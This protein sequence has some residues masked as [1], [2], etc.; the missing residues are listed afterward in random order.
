[1][2]ILVAKSAGFCYGVKRAIKIAEETLKTDG[3]CYT[4][5]PIIHNP[6]VVEELRKK[7]LNVIEDVKKMKK[8]TLIIRSH[9]IS[10]CEADYLAEKGDK[11]RVVDT[12]CPFVTKA[13]KLLEILKKERYEIFFLGDKAHPEVKGLLS[14]IDNDAN[15]FLSTEEI[16]VKDYKKVGLIS[17][18]TQKIELLKKSAD[19]LLGM[20]LE[21]R[22]F[23]TICK[24]T[25]VRQKEA[26]EMA[27]KVDMMIVLG[28]KNSSNTRKLAE[29]CK[30]VLEKTYHIESPED[31]D[32]RWFEGVKRVGIT[33]GASTP[34]EHINELI[35]NIEKIKKG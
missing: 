4:L 26:L 33:A 34:K 7:G 12:T 8:G 13:R 25:S 20:S 31:I 23:N 29:I 15:V 17:Q 5:G 16:P 9:G 14:Y 18:T 3:E 27:K 19:R 2:E 21:L 35:E 10:K 1:M 6:K 24:T 22:V 32:K 30:G 28:G 11:I